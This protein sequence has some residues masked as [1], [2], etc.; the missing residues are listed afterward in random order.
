MSLH[1]ALA[2]L[3]AATTHLHTCLQ[4]ALQA[5]VCVLA[6]LHASAGLA[7]QQIPQPVTG[8]AVSAPRQLSTIVLGNQDKHLEIDKLSQYW[9]DE[10]GE[11]T[12]E[13][14]IAGQEGASI[15]N[16]RQQA[17]RHAIH[18]KAL[19]IRFNTQITDARSAWF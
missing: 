8:P 11:A 10:S 6:L 18:N 9:I 13:Q 5:A 1:F 7:L 12:I 2:L 19:W 3:R 4:P 17:Q 15:F 16:P 14:V